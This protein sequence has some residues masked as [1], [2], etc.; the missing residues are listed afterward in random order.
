MLTNCMLKLNQCISSYLHRNYS[1][2]LIN[3]FDNSILSIYCWNFYS[4]C[5]MPLWILGSISCRRENVYFSY[6]G[7]WCVGENNL[8]TQV[9]NIYSELNNLS[10]TCDCTIVICCH[11]TK[12][13]EPF[14][15]KCRHSCKRTCDNETF[16]YVY[17]VIYYL[18]SETPCSDSPCFNG[19]SCFI[20]DS[21]YNCSCLLGYTGS[22][23]EGTT[24]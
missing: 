3:V 20:S 22:R 6:M 5:S 21:S 24:N 12:V 19:G 7:F 1:V 18:F 23:C 16:Q 13:T 15:F 11:V 8:D 14:S 17:A 4:R 9:T 10:I 2:K